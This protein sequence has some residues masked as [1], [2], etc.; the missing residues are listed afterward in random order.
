M[1]RP[2]RG[3]GDG[4]A[5][6]VVVGTQSRVQIAVLDRLAKP[7]VG[8]AHRLEV[9]LGEALDGLAH[10]DLVHRRDDVAGVADGA[11]SRPS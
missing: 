5:V 4:H 6:Q 11:L 1:Q 7:P 9:G 2:V 8:L 3:H 10:G